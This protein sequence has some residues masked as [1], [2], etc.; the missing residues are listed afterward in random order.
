MGLIR[1][2]ALATVSILQKSNIIIEKPSN[3]GNRGSREEKKSSN[4]G[5]CVLSKF[6]TN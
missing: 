5:G 4:G 1:N 6:S 2:I 3:L